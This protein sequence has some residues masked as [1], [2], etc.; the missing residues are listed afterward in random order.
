M[1]LSP[2]TFGVRSTPP[3]D[4]CSDGQC[5]M[6]CGPALSRSAPSVDAPK[7]DTRRSPK[8]AR[9]VVAN[10]LKAVDGLDFFPT[11]PWA[12]RALVTEVLTK[13]EVYDPSHSLLEPCCGMGHMVE[14]L[15]EFFAGGVHA[16][17]IRD[18]G[19]GY[20][21]GS[22]MA[23]PLGL[24]PVAECPFEPDWVITNPPFNISLEIVL[25][26]LNVA[27]RGVAMLLPTRWV[28]SEE[29]HKRVF[30]TLAPD[31]IAFF[32]G[33]VS[34]VENR[35]DPAVNSASCY[36]W[37]VWFAGGS[38]RSSSTAIWISPDAEA[39]NTRLDDVERFG[40]LN[41]CACE[42][43]AVDEPVG[44]RHAVFCPSFR[45]PRKRPAGGTRD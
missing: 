11:P 15:R 19:C 30:T 24:L 45:P 22:F 10:R 13:T 43:H 36:S 35:W 12:S 37:F 25:R 1:S 7:R 20:D 26:A 8:N 44:D 33:R 6:N 14:P 41:A 31:V 40:A 2:I 16:S 9:A 3:C 27:R 23:D 4:D 42:C 29:R 34:M 18:Y 38:P 28:E 32:S 5:T 21:A 17:D 39:R